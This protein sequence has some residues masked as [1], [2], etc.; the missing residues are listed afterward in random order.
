M[1]N[2]KGREV[3]L[4]DG[5]VGD[6][7]LSDKPGALLMDIARQRLSPGVLFVRLEMQLSHTVVIL[8]TNFAAN[9]QC[10]L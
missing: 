10:K 6:G 8:G 1:F 9:N 4:S 5:W 2:F 3:Y 7:F